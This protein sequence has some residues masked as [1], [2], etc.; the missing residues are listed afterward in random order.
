MSMSSQTFE[1]DTSLLVL[2]D[3][4]HALVLNEHFRVT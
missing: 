3:V 2:F 1:L 4:F